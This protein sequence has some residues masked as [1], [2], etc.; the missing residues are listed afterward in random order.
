MP[1]FSIE[2]TFLGTVAG[3]DEAGR[4]PLAG[5]VAASAVII[6]RNKIAPSLAAALNDSKKL[7]AK[8]RE[9]LLLELENSEAVTIGFALA[10]V[11]EID[12]INIL[13]ASLLAMK[14]AF[15]NLSI[16][17]DFAIVDGNKP[18][19]L[20]CPVTTVVK[21]DAKSV[22]I[23]AASIVAKVRRDKIMSEIALEYPQ[24]GFEKH[25]GYGTKSH[26]DAIVK[27]GITPHHR[28]TFAPIKNMVF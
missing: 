28:K 26:I 2:E 16:K 20:I 25:A 14:R 4:G 3:L 15:E 10:S 12:E 9:T 19:K 27:Y 6:D 7:T 23:A 1:D 17:P 22:S 21:G 11:A 13:Q 5:P 18:P 8:K 24:Y